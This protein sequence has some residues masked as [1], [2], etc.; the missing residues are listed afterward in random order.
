MFEKKYKPV[1]L[2]ELD[3]LIDDDSVV[4]IYTTDKYGINNRVDLSS[5]DG[6]KM[7]PKEILRW[8]YFSGPD[9]LVRANVVVCDQN[10]LYKGNVVLTR[11]L[12]Q[13]P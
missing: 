8:F 10:D 5:F 3:S 2:D 9:G 6:D 12:G 1:G 4:N 13:G 11:K 7:D